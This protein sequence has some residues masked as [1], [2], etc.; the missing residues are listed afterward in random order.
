MTPED[1]NHDI[2][3]LADQAAASDD[4]EDGPGLIL[5][6]ADTWCRQGFVLAT[7]HTTALRGIRHRNIR[8]WISSKSEDRV[9]SR[10]EARLQGS[11]DFEDLLPDASVG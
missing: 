2:K 8:V 3:L 10:R 5:L 7:E 1:I 9:L 6:S 11:E 4:P